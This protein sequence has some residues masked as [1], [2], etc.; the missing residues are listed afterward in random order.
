MVPAYGQR[1][2][3]AS[4]GEA[5]VGGAEWTAISADLSDT[6]EEVE[7]STYLLA[8]RVLDLVVASVALLLLSPLMLVTAAIIKLTDGGSVFYTST[9]VGYR[10]REFD[11]FKFRSMV[12]NADDLKDEFLDQSH[13][14]DSRT[15]KIARDP[16]LTAIGWFIRKFSID[17]LPQLLNVLR[18]DMSLVGPRPPVP[19][20]VAQYSLDDMRRLEVQPGLT[21]IWQVSGR[22][23]LPFPEQLKMDLKYIE[24]RCLWTDV[25]LLCRTVPAV[26]STRGAY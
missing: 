3:L 9:R 12:E 17:E 1:F 18:G 24:T 5:L 7:R 6:L 21:C 19:R 26:L 22:S 2:A 14:G 13:H 10:G 16:R 11:C 25:V 4:D 8:K 23:N 15:F 20:E